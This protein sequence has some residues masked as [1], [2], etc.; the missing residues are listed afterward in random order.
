MSKHLL[1]DQI[2]E[3]QSEYLDLLKTLKPMIE[4]EEY[5]SVALDSISLFW[6]KKRPVI[7]VYLQYI[8]K[9]QNGVFYTA[10]TYFDVNN[11]EQYPFMLMGN[12][13]IFD[14]PL[15][16]Y[17]EICHRW[18]EA[19]KSIFEKISVCAN[20]NIEL[21]EKCEG[22]VTILPLR[23][24]G[25][26]DEE[27]ER[28]KTGEKVFLNFFDDIP[29]MDSYYMSCTTVDDIVNS[30][31]EDYMSNVCL[32]EG[33]SKTE[34]FRIRVENAI[35][36]QKTLIGEGYSLGLYFST[37]L[38]GPL[39]QAIDILCLSSAYNLIPLIRYPVALHNVYMLLPNFFD[40]TH[41]DIRA[42]IVVFNA[43]YNLFDQ[44]LFAKESLSVFYEKVTSFSFE[45]KALSCYRIKNP[46]Q[47]LEDLHSLLDD[48]RDYSLIQTDL[49]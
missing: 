2:K 25:S 8:A 4:D 19:P 35:D 36:I 44:T 12:L 43:L 9:E 13:H 10:A 27:Q 40:E 16:K 24:M 33:D 23:G 29:D 17:C 41:E 31:K 47:T 21:L 6:H 5:V 38:M 28:I 42:R 22:L 20:D 1:E 37:S 46:K 32:Y 49:S 3:I 34:D 14:D 26:T 45:T 7:D 30:F 39:Q 11:G 48:F 18:S 15:G